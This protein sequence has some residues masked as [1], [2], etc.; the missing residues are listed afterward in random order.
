MPEFYAYT[1]IPDPNC[2]FLTEL[3]VLQIHELCLPDPQGW[4]HGQPHDSRGE[5]HYLY[6]KTIIEDMPPT[7]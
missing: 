4:S 3:F 2:F 7:V 1:S 5:D 6:V